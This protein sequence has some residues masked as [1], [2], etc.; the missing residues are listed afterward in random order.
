MH[1]LMTNCLCI[2]IITALSVLGTTAV[3]RIIIGVGKTIIDAI[4]QHGG[5]HEKQR[6]RIA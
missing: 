2:L 5:H 6:I 3:V 1:D 4:N